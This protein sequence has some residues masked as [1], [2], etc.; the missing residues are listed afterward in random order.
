MT[1]DLETKKYLFVYDGTQWYLKLTNGE[2]IADYHKKTAGNRY[3]GA[4]RLYHKLRCEKKEPYDLLSGL[5]L[6]ERI[7]MMESKDFKYIQCALIKACQA[8]GTILDGFRL[9]TMEIGMTQLENIRNYGAVFINA[10]G[11]HTHGIKTVQF[12]WRK[13]L[14]FPNFTKEDI[15]VKQFQGGRHWYAFV[16]DMQVRDGEHLKRNTQKAAQD[17]AE[18]VVGC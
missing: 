6:E 11:G 8:E 16:G 4:L 14:V 15:V 3:E 5:P 18:K 1:N 17:A 2:Q 9:L 7:A 13:E 10:A 12:C